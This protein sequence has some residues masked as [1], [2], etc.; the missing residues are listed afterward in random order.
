MQNSSITSAMVS[1]KNLKGILGRLPA[2]DAHRQVQLSCQGKLCPEPFLLYLPGFL[3][4]III[5]ADLPYRHRLLP[6]A[7]FPDP[8]ELLFIQGS[9][10]VRMNARRSIDKRILLRQLRAGPGP[11]KAGSY[12]YNF[13]DSRSRHPRQQF[14]SVFIKS[15]IIIMSM[16]VKYHC[17]SLHLSVFER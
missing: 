7:E 8:L 15:F 14:F 9:Y 13:P 11:L 10:L 1:F 12:I 6:A 16:A 5:Q 3:I 2:V 17:K 4:P